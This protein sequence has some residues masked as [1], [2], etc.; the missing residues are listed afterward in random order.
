MEHVDF[1]DAVLKDSG[2][3]RGR[4]GLCKELNT[5]K[6]LKRHPHGNKVP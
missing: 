5:K 2:T 6:T 3:G 1:I 4:G